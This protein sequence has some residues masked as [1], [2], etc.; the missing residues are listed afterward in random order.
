MPG[1]THKSE[2]RLF[3]SW[4]RDARLRANLTQEEVAAAWGTTQSVISKIER[5]E[6]RLDLV[7]FISY[8]EVLDV[9]PEDEFRR[10]LI[11]IRG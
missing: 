11:A 8:C 3:T 10:V 7:Q 6:R 4:I 1:F 5:G 2:Y 9:S